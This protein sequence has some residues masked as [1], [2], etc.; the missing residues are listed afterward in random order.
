MRRHRIR[1]PEPATWGRKQL[2]T[3]LAGTVVAAV[4]LLF[5]LGLS[6]YYTLRSADPPNT[7]TSEAVSDPY[8]ALAAR[9]MPTASVEAARP[10]PLTTRPFRSLTLPSGRQLGPAGVTT[11]FPPTAEGAL[12]Q[13]VALD[14]AVLQSASVPEA[15][16]LIRAWA[17]RGGPT[18]TTW[19]GVRAVAEMLSA[20]E[21]PASGSP[22]FTV[23]A[24]PELGL[25]KGTVGSRYVVACV[26]FVVTATGVRTARV[27]AADCQRM[28]WVRDDRGVWRWMIGP[29]SEPAQPPSVWPGTEVAHRAGYLRLGFEDDQ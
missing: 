29:G 23:S 15:Q 25:V 26:N 21:V 11:G 24:T 4:L 19:S 2:L 22:S 1:L 13:L 12:A 9:P 14:Q 28:V 20:A 16:R 8:D 6:V 7:T 5:G 10:G 18:P 17:R 27:A 3:L